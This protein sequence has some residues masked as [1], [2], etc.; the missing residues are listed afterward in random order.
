MGL[1]DNRIGLYEKALPNAMNWSSKMTAAKQAG[2]DFIEISVDESDM[3]LD[4]LNYAPKAIKELNALQQELNMPI[5]SMCLSGHRR[6]PF[7]SKDEAKR[8]RAYEIMEKALKLAVKLNIGNIQLAGYDVYYETSD[9]DTVKRFIEGLKWSAKRA[10]HYSVM[11]SLEVMDT[12]F[13]GTINKAVKYVDLVNSPYLK[14]YP[15]LGNLTQ[16]SDNPSEELITNK[17]HIVA[18]HLKDTKPNVF[19]CVNFGS[20]TVAFEPLF[21]TLT[22]IEYEGPFLVEMWA[23][24]TIDEPFEQ[25]VK[26]IESA[27]KWLLERMTNAC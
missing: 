1:K 5:V 24:N 13:M 8:D 10:E 22:K 23:D 19:K 15:D 4:R 11:L 18:I 2:F 7:G 26:R 17:Q 6:F 25:T 3:R 14:V 20:G 9:E 16:F 12:P 27:R 21:K